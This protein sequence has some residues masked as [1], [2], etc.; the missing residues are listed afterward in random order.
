MLPSSKVLL[1]TD[2]KGDTQENL[3]GIAAA[4]CEFLC[5]GAFTQELQQ[6]YLKLQRKMHKIDYYPRSQA[7]REPEDRD[8]YWAHEVKELLQGEV[9]GQKV[10]QRYRLIFVWSEARAKQQG[11][12]RERHENK[13]RQEFEKI[14]KNLNKY[15]LKKRED[16]LARLEKAK[17]KYDEGSLFHYE[18]KGRAG[19]FR[20][21]WWLDEKQQKEWKELQG[22]YVVK[23]NR[24]RGTYPVV[25]VLRTYKEQSSVE[26]RI[27]HIKG[28]LA[29]APAFLEN[30]KRIAGLMAVVVW[31]LLIMA[32]LERQLRRGLKGKPMFGLYPENRACKAPSGPT[33][34]KS[35]S[36]LCVVIFLDE[37]GSRRQLAQLTAVQRRLLELLD[38]LE[39]DLYCYAR[40]S[41]P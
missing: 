38:I 39:T 1:I 33:I 21:R 20:L 41:Y 13:I 35:F 36:T 37:G 29:V 32:L 12:T 17:G 3:L 19:Q 2:S 18:L 6:R 34:L 16:I 30:P 31:A 8:E 27:G 4:G 5:T 25:E 7:E 15:K 26:K 14:E 22:V 10:R 28:P 9:N 24:D 40:S 11:Q 23:T